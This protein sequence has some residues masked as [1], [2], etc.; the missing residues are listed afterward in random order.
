MS[1]VN[2]Q[3][4][5]DL[6][7]QYGATETLDEF[8]KVN[9][10]IISVDG[11][12]HDLNMIRGLMREDGERNFSD[13]EVITFMNKG[14]S[15]DYDLDA[16][17][18]ATNAASSGLLGLLGTPV[19]LV[20][21]ITSGIESVVRTGANKL[22]SINAPEG[23]DDPSSPNFNPD[24][25]L[26]EDP[27]D[28]LFSSTKPIGGKESIA[29]TV[30][31][32]INPIYDAVGLPKIDYKL[33]K[34]EIPPEHRTLY[35][36][37]EIGTET[38]PLVFG[39]PLVAMS[40]AGQGKKVHAF[41]DE[42]IKDPKKF[43]TTETAATAGGAMAVGVAEEA[44]IENPY[45][46]MGIEFLGN[47]IGGSAA[48]TKGLLESTIRGANK[49]PIVGAVLKGQSNTA[50]RL[51]AFEELKRNISDTYDSLLD[52]AD[53]YERDAA[54]ATG[55]EREA[56]I[57]Q[58]N[59]A[60]LEAEN[61]KLENVF[62]SMEKGYQNIYGLGD[63]F[64]QVQTL[65]TEVFAGNFDSNP[66]LAALQKYFANNDSG[67]QDEVIQ[68]ARESIK[69]MLASAEAI[70]RG[71]NPEAAQVMTN[72]AYQQAVNMVMID[73]QDKAQKLLQGVKRNAD[74]AT[75]MAAS[76][77]ANTIIQNA[78]SSMKEVEDFLW[79]RVPEQTL[80]K[81][82][83][84]L[85]GIRE[86]YDGPSRKLFTGQSLTENQTLD[87][88]VARLAGQD[89][90]S[91]ADLKLIRTQFLELARSAGS[92]RGGQQ[93]PRSVSALYKVAD[94]ALKDILDSDIPEEI[95]D[96]FNL[97]RTF[98]AK[99]HERFDTGFT[100]Q[101]LGLTGQAAS[102]LQIDPR[103]T[104]DQATSGSGQQVAV[105]MSDL[106]QSATETDKA[107]NLEN[108]VR[109]SDADRLSRGLGQSDEAS[110]DVVP[111][112]GPIAYGSATFG[113]TGMPFKP[114]RPKNPVEG[115][116]YDS[117]SATNTFGGGFSMPDYGGDPRKPEFRDNNPRTR[118]RNDIFPPVG[119]ETDKTLN[120]M[121]GRNQ[122]NS[123]E[124]DPPK[125][126]SE[127]DFQ[128][129]AEEI[130]GDDP[131]ATIGTG[132]AGPDANI[133]TREDDTV[134]L[135]QQMSEAQET[136]LRNIIYTNL[137][138][139]KTIKN[140]EGLNETLQTL[141]PAKVAEWKRQNEV[142]LSQFPQLAVDVDLAIDARMVMDRMDADLSAIAEGNLSQN[143]KEILT[144]NV[145]KLAR[146]EELKQVSSS[147][148]QAGQNAPMA[149]LRN[150]IMDFVFRASERPTDA[151]ID[152][153]ESG[154]PNFT[155][156]AKNL[157]T[158]INDQGMNLLDALSY[159][160]PNNPNDYPILQ[161]NEVEAVAR[162]LLEGINIEKSLSPR[163]TP[164]EVVTPTGDLQTNLARIVGANIGATFGDGGAS[165]QTAQIV[166]GQF[167]KLVSSLPLANQKKA[168]QDLLKSPRILY[169]MYS[170][171]PTVSQTSFQAYKESII[172]RYGEK[173]ARGVAAKLA[174]DAAL[175]TVNVVADGITNTPLTAKIGPPLG[176][177][178]LPD[179]A[180]VQTEEMLSEEEEE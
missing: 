152:F 53:E 33:D 2:L 43:V 136:F 81:N 38:L 21:T 51:S 95:K 72:N 151:S 46:R 32:V 79:S 70:S 165:L 169:G 40:K 170:R 160:N 48:N 158:P 5:N 11:E 92:G 135:G 176:E 138:D 166:S 31:T 6:T 163:V 60:R 7:S 82:T 113:Q 49:L 50:A 45:A 99:L 12:L 62:N 121:F 74:Q 118:T 89:E 73:A 55:S 172:N 98:S 127:D 123:P 80:V 57:S 107:K 54:Q 34:M 112:E 15:V 25:Y 27:Q 26:S 144:G 171:N 52:K 84:F 1:S 119:S 175:G 128:R 157:L 114:V 159:K 100:A 96:S 179:D 28:F 147:M 10:P 75:A 78:K 61:Y 14:A 36:M 177:K 56:L 67:F 66:A 24:F 87:Q 154:S 103:L 115:E 150:S 117:D 18:T 30:E 162:F 149:A 3:F 101:L 13:E 126:L 120:N 58:A 102:D 156:I 111:T 180:I 125:N 97:A 145:D 68:N 23:V 109:S 148:S 35:T 164:D 42:I 63:D 17:G 155:A 131:D 167:K 91:I 86:I 20:N 139:E 110:T 134:P 105:Q 47:L 173:G 4:L 130:Y 85:D 39:L 22:A 9:G 124:M 122:N 161:P 132:P 37:V 168:M 94:A 88:I 71:G 142:T 64:D 133:V 59:S 178:G 146:L 8:I 106:Q 76:Q 129:M 44:Q 108:V 116:A 83:K 174:T 141:S 69:Y 16:A 19:D 137:L 104:L 29:E 143:I 41:W 140:S 153:G 77:E 65:D 90:V 93:Q